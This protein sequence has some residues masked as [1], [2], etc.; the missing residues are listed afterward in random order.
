[1]A[2]RRE[3]GGCFF[4]S[5]VAAAPYLSRLDLSVCPFIRYVEAI[6][7]H[8]L[9]FLRI[10][11][12]HEVRSVDVSALEALEELA[13]ISCT[14]LES[15]H[16]G[17]AVRSMKGVSCSALT[18]IDLRR[19]LSLERIS[20]YESL[21][22][23]TLHLPGNVASVR[24]IQLTNVP[25]RFSLGL[26]GECGTL[27]G[28]KLEDCANAEAVQLP[29]DFAAL[30]ALVLQGLSARL[31]LDLRVCSRLR[32]LVL[33]DCSGMNELQL[34]A[35]P[36][37]LGAFELRHCPARFLVNFSSCRTLRYFVLQNCSGVTSLQFPTDMSS[38]VRL[39][40]TGLA[41]TCAIRHDTRAA[42]L[43]YTRAPDRQ[44]A[45][46]HHGQSHFGWPDRLSTCVDFRANMLP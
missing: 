30:K 4:H 37:W 44:H 40:V 6:N 7:L 22:L 39:D 9:T 1:M 27:E 10:T 3:P 41:P 17:S 5:L 12:C 46:P 32:R 28:L 42:M 29:T 43:E 34:P 21:R 20:V 38:V 8:W 25:A 13:L 35:S 16:T 26:R 15:V 18:S 2:A 23:V 14:M 11:S 36:P 19:V 33:S 31:E 45:M 24:D